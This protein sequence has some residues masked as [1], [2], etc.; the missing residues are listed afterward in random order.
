[1]ELAELAHGANSMVARSLGGLG[2]G[3]EEEIPNSYHENLWIMVC[4]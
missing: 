3:W 4:E 1:M 2:E